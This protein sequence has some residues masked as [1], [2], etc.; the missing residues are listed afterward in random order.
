M[1]LS[2]SGEWNLSASPD[3]Q[4]H[5]LASAIDDLAQSEHFIVPGEPE[6]IEKAV[7]ELMA[8]TSRPPWMDDDM[9]ATYDAALN[10]A[11]KDYPIDVVQNA[12]KRWRQIPQQGRW[13]PTEQD[14][15]AQCELLFRPRKSLFNRARMLLTDLRAKEQA[16]ERAKGSPFASDKGREFRNEM[17]KRMRPARFD[18]YFDPSQIM[19]SEREV[20][21][22]TM[23]GERV[24]SEEGR[25]VLERLGLRVRYMPQA[26]A[27]IRQPTWEDDTPAEREEVTRKFNRLKEAM[28]NGENL[29]RLRE[30]GEI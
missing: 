21:V 22:R 3:L 29:K 25:D 26:F 16:D 1:S 19:F 18:A 2:T 14:L 13:W 6:D 9:A 8:A 7:T 30:L 28:A 10:E 5:A 4:A 27:K 15:R 23:T 12:C 24:L 17:R 11:M 20:W